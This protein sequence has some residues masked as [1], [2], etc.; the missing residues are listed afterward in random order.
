MKKVDA[1]EQFKSC[2]MSYTEMMKNCQIYSVG[3]RSEETRLAKNVYGN[4]RR[5]GL[6]DEVR[7]KCELGNPK[8]DGIPY[9]EILRLR[10]EYVQGIRTDETKKANAI[11]QRMLRRGWA[12]RLKERCK[13]LNHENN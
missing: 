9:T 5:H 11:Y 8:V 3:I 1:L 12:T 13:G 2:G 4:L 10:K 6:L 7:P